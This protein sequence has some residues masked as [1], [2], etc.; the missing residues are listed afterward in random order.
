MAVTLEIPKPRDETLPAPE[1]PV[2]PGTAAVP[3]GVAIAADLLLSADP[4]ADIASS[5][6]SLSVDAAGESR[7]EA[8]AQAAYL[9][10][11]ARGFE[12]GHE[13][14]DWLAAEQQLT[15]LC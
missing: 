11:E 9:L 5:E 12:P 2:A 6:P 1:A 14:D 7:H 10:A 15:A 8:I 4:S 13:L 3:T